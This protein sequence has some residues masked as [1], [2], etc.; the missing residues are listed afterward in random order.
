MMRQRS[1]NSIS[2]ERRQSSSSQQQQQQQQ[3]QAAALLPPLP[4]M[5]ISKRRA[6]VGTEWNHHN[7][8]DDTSAII[9][10]TTT[11]IELPTPQWKLYRTAHHMSDAQYARSSYHHHQHQQQQQQQQSQS[12]YD[13]N[14]MPVLHKRPPPPFFTKRG[15]VTTCASFS[16]IAIFVLLLLGVLLDTQPFYVH[17]ALMVQQTYVTN[18]HN[19]VRTRPVHMLPLERLPAAAT[20]YQTAFLY[21]LTYS[22]CQ[23]YLQQQQQHQQQQ[24][25]NHHSQCCSWRRRNKQRQYQDIPDYPHQQQQASSFNELPLHQEYKVVPRRYMASMVQRYRVEWNQYM[26]QWGWNNNNNSHR[27]GKHTPKTI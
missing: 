20:A 18:T 25:S 8:G 7:N 3:Q 14:S 19:R 6:R 1:H 5:G 2:P 26:S 9:Y 17:G 13:D 15:C 4:P 10:K 16:F 12:S 27:R 24:A 11:I 23:W 22:A 21:L